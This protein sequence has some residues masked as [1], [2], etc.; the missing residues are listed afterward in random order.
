MKIRSRKFRVLSVTAI[1]LIAIGFGVRAQFADDCDLDQ[2]PF[3]LAG[4]LDGN[5]CQTGC[6]LVDRSHVAFGALGGRM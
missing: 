2:S 5:A 4:S 1:T 6:L 3:A